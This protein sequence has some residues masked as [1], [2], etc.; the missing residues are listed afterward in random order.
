MI[1]SAVSRAEKKP[2]TARF[3]AAIASVQGQPAL[4]V[5]GEPRFLQAPF[6]FKAP[7]DTF[8]AARCGLYMISDPP[9][10]LHPD[11]TVGTAD[12]E[13]EADAVLAREPDALLVL[14]TCLMAP[15][16]WMDANPDDVMRFDRDL[17]RYEGLSYHFGGGFR[18]ASYGSDRWLEL[19]KRGYEQVCA[20]LHERYGGR[21]ILYQFGMGTCGENHPIGACAPDGRWFCADFSPAMT[22]CFR[23]WL[24]AKYGTDAALRAGWSMPGVTLDTAAVPPREDRARA[25]G[26]R[27]GCAAAWA[28]GRDR[29]LRRPVD[30]ARGHGVPRH[31][32]KT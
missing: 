32:G 29:V 30:R 27:E 22:A 23:R 15:D 13:R 2:K 1:E 12:I 14:R 3:R 9:F 10:P 25:R 19:L 28:G 16:W 5:N 20:R 24:R 21:V 31:A 26:G 4:V 17:T 11:G 8:A 18:D 7:Y 6:L